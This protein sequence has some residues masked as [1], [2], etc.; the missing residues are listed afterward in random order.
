MA[1]DLIT[2]ELIENPAVTRLMTVASYQNNTHKWRIAGSEPPPPPEPQKK[3]VA[4]VAVVNSPF[5]TGTVGTYGPTITT[6]IETPF[7]DPTGPELTPP[8]EPPPPAPEIAPSGVIDGLRAQYKATSGKDADGRWGVKKLSE[9]IKL[10]ETA[11][12]Q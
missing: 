1:K 7:V 10:L 11:A 2:V 8:V 12:P 5:I 9:E 4:P 3:S 6:T